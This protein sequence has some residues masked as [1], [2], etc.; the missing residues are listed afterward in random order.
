MDPNLENLIEVFTLSKNEDQSDEFKNVLM[1]IQKFFDSNS[2]A[3]KES[4]KR[5][6]EDLQN[7]LWGKSQYVLKTCRC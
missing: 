6:P 4:F 7:P 2:S 5:M 3:L 1:R